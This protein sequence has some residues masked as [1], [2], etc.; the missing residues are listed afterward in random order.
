MAAAFNT[1]GAADILNGC[2]EKSLPDVDIKHLRATCEASEYLVVEPEEGGDWS[3]LIR[4]CPQA[5]VNVYSPTD[6]YP[7]EMW[8][9]ASAY[10][11][12][13]TGEEMHLP[14]GRYSCAQALLARNLPFLIGRS[15]GQVC[16]IVQLAISQKKL[17]GYLNGAVVPYASS[18]S[19]VKE[20]CAVWQQPC[21][22]NVNQAAGT[23][24]STLP[25]ASWET[26]RM[27][28]RDILDNA[29][30]SGSGPGIV[31]LSNVKRLFRSRFHVEL[32]ETMLGHSKLS[33]LLQDPH[34]QDIC[35]VQ[36]QG[37]G[38]IVVQVQ[39]PEGH[40]ISLAENIPSYAG[41][42]DLKPDSAPFEPTVLADD[43]P[44]RVEFCPDEPLI[45]EDDAVPSSNVREVMEDLTPAR[46]RLPT[47][48]P[49][50]LC[51]D[52]LVGSMV[53]STF[54][55]AAPPPPT[56]PAGTRRRS[57]SLP[58]DVGSEKSDWEM[59]CHALG[60][61]PRPMG[62]SHEPDESTA[63]SLRSKAR[64]AEEH[65]TRS[66]SSGTASSPSPSGCE[67]Q[68]VC[69][70]QRPAL[71]DPVK[72]LLRECKQYDTGPSL[73]AG[74]NS[75]DS[76]DDCTPHS[77]VGGAT[78]P[79]RLQFC[80]DEPLSFEDAEIFMEPPSAV[81]PG[82]LSPNRPRPLGIPMDDWL[83]PN[84][85]TPLALT[86]THTNSA[87]S[88]GNQRGAFKRLAPVPRWPTLSPT[89]LVKDGW[90]GPTIGS[91]ALSKVQNTF[92][93]SPL[94]PPT[95]LR[96]GASRRSRSLPKDV[97]S[98]KDAWEVTCHALGVCGVMPRPKPP[99]NPQ[100][101]G[102]PDLSFFPGYTPSV[103]CSLASSPAFVPPS[104]ALTASPTYCSSRT[105][106]PLLIPATGPPTGPPSP[107]RSN[108]VLR[109]ADLL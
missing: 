46:A 74:S 100:D 103:P 89:P 73:F 78:A 52:G 10:F 8:A 108:P 84:A 77:P 101:C 88:G 15:L 99:V 102:E 83:S 53:R 24:P 2:N 22:T 36:L 79:A 35:T 69:L 26:A 55:H 97:G 80:P 92:I 109:L 5:F 72:V 44:R 48:S 95:P 43:E 45:L 104:P 61:M 96:I 58:K 4:G 87:A 1:F 70:D 29:A 57:L 60:F 85:L 81:R 20:Q 65:S 18:Q 16:H 68:S 3:A 7:A 107:T 64:S 90:V 76:L 50:T 39:A 98:D 40:T 86:P 33:E 42:S 51:K 41:L 37:H 23:T 67:L 106:R 82:S 59:A 27:C 32:S 49:S 21:T 19:M 75:N 62:L 56:P 14:G 54:I 31:P 94:P 91:I 66:G 105:P 47:L 34:F 25:M 71:D 93:H 11:E 6:V 9:A 12:V 28:L 17:L 63:D 38:Y 30:R 13:L